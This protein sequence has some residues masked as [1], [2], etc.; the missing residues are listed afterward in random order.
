MKKDAG[1]ASFF[2]VADVDKNVGF[3][4]LFSR[5]PTYLFGTLAGR[6]SGLTYIRLAV[7]TTSLW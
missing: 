4:R 2:I 3:V 5:V 7:K 1:K 6:R